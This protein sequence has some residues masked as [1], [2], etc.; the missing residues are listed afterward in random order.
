[1]PS[2]GREV[3]RVFFP[4]PACWT[5]ALRASLPFCPVTKGHLPDGTGHPRGL[6]RGRRR[7]CLVTEHAGWFPRGERRKLR[8]RLVYASAKSG[9]QPFSRKKTSS[10]REAERRARPAQRQG[11]VGSAHQAASGKKPGPGLIA[12]AFPVLS[13]ADYPALAASRPGHEFARALV[14][15][16][17]FSVCRRQGA[18][19][20]T[21]DQSNRQCAAGTRPAPTLG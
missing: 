6:H 11:L 19:D 15:G 21:D 17:L 9:A 10:S 12:A 7:E 5:I 20:R 8:R 16:L 3:I 1:M 13:A 4:C 14:P 18:R 2:L